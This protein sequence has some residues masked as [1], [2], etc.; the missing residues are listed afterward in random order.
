MRLQQLAFYFARWLGSP[1]H[2]VQA[3]K[4]AIAPLGAAFTE[5]EEVVVGK[6]LGSGCDRSG[7]EF[8]KDT[9]VDGGWEKDAV[10][11]WKDMEEL[12]KL[13]RARLVQ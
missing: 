12:R 4:G 3:Y 11:A 6:K 13:W 10:K 2:G 9:N 5:P 7:N 8:V 1:W